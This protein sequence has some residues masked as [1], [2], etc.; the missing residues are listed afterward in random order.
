M[1]AGGQRAGVRL[2]QNASRTFSCDSP[3]RPDL[4]TPTDTFG[5]NWEW[6]AQSRPP[7]GCRL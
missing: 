4:L 5:W 2:E 7:A 6:F 1:Y 3:A